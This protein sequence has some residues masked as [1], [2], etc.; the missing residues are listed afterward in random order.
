MFSWHEKY[1]PCSYIIAKTFECR[2]MSQHVLIGVFNQRLRPNTLLNGLKTIEIQPKISVTQLF[3]MMDF[4]CKGKRK[5]T[6][7]LFR[8]PAFFDM[9]IFS[10]QLFTVIYGVDDSKPVIHIQQSKVCHDSFFQLPI[11]FS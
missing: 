10:G 7:E 2:L 6:E 5:R 8:S 4:L 1:L 9:P 3:L 11:Y